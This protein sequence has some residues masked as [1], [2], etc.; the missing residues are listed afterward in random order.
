MPDASIATQFIEW[1]NGIILS[2][3]YLG[4]FLVSFIGA[5]SIIFPVPSFIIVFALGAVMN[6]WIVGIV[7][8]IGNALGELTG[9]AFGKG[10]GKIIEKKYKKHVE[11]YKKW[12]KKDRIFLLIVLFAATPLPDDILG[13][14]CG[15]FDYNI[16][17]FIVASI[18][19]KIIL[20]LALALGGFYGIRF[21]LTIMGG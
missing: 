18:I 1:S 15:M 11:K 12:F 20:N 10:G 14:V 2:L 6:P 17:K 7:A 9:Y 13:L 3:G 16:K 5:A 8:G 21:V 19:G 4:V